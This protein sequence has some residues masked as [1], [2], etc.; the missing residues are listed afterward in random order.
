M[1]KR[2]SMFGALVAVAV[3]AS[4]L[5]AAEKAAAPEGGKAV[6]QQHPVAKLPA[7]KKSRP[8]RAKHAPAIGSRNEADVE[9]LSGNEPELL[10]GNRAELLSR[11]EPELLSGNRASL[12]SGNSARLLSKIQVLSGIKIEVNITINGGDKGGPAGEADSV[13]SRYDRDGDGRL[14][15]AE[16]R[17]S[18]EAKTSPASF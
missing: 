7:V 15:P 4:D 6:K 13:F 11:N 16:F 1:W 18:L 3:L 10:S 17:R 5:A 2:A 14:S 8:K 12:L 9:L